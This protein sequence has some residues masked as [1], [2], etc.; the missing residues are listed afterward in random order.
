MDGRAVSDTAKPW[1]DPEHPGN[2]IRP[3]V[4]CAGCGTKGCVTYWGPWC[5]ACNVA[6]MTRLS[7]TFDRLAAD[8]RK[9]ES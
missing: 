2:R 7:A 5:L 1:A 6:R 3:N 4:R 8:L 9:I